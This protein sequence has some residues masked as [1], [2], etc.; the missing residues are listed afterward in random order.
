MADCKPWQLFCKGGEIISDSANDA[1]KEAA[2][3]IMNLAGDI[4]RMVSTWWMA[5]PAPDLEAEAVTQVQ[6]D[7]I[8]YNAAFAIIG[9]LF[10]LG[11]MVLS[12][13]FKS[14]IG[15]GRMIVNLIMV[16]SVYALGLTLLIESGDAFSEWILKRAG[17]GTD[18][19]VFVLATARWGA[20]PTIFLGLILTCGALATFFFMLFRNVMMTISMAILPTVAAA[21]G[22]EAG[23]QAFKKMN[24]WLLAFVLFKPVAAVIYALGLYFMANP[25]SLFDSAEEALGDAGK[26]L[27]GLAILILAALALPAL[28]KFLVPVAAH[29]SGAF[30]GGAALGTAVTVAAGAAV[31][32][33][34]AGAGAAAVAGGGAGAGAGAGGMASGGGGAASLGGGSAPAAPTSGGPSGSGGGPSGSGGSDQG[35]PTSGSGDSGSGGD[36][37]PSDSGGTSGSAAEGNS[38]DS[39]GSQQSNSSAASG[40]DNGG[41]SGGDGGG[42]STTASGESGSKDGKPADSTASGAEGSKGGDSKSSSSAAPG[43]D[44]S[45]SGGGSGFSLSDFATAANSA[46]DMGE[47]IANA[48]GQ[49]VDSQ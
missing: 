12:N 3:S 34:T 2:E 22:T 38:G 37:K 21:S 9:L 17:Q 1:L 44:S 26:V 49:A 36:S 8:W 19:T 18:L 39:G 35:A 4:M 10:A 48:P 41:G 27:M 42:D 28:I 40:S 5:A 47:S 46:A 33:A 23:M 13:D 45:S 31:I 20:F 15:A 29:G 14:L 11:K 25:V 6:H 24:G 7:L 16:T 32:G 43:S 30:S